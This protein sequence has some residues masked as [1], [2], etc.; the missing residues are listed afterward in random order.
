MKNILF[1]IGLMITIGTAGAS[2]LDTISIAQTMVQGIAGLGLMV[3][4]VV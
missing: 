1:V 2:D 4:G 3:I